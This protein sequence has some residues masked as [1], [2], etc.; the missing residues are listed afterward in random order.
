MTSG[1]TSGRPC[2][3]QPPC[4]LA[5]SELGPL[6]THCSLRG[7]LQI[8]LIDPGQFRV[9]TDLLQKETK[10]KGRMETLNFAAVTGEGNLD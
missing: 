6:L 10:G 4:P 1:R 5:V 2:V 3:D 9:L 7:H 8:M